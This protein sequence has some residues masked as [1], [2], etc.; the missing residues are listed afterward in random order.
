MKRAGGSTEVGRRV[1]RG[2]RE[3]AARAGVL[4]AELRAE[5]AATARANTAGAARRRRRGARYPKEPPLTPAGEIIA[6]RTAGWLRRMVGAPALTPGYETELAR[7][8]GPDLFG[9]LRLPDPPP[10]LAEVR[11]ETLD[12]AHI[13]PLLRRISMTGPAPDPADLTPAALAT[14]PGPVSA[15]HRTPG[16]RRW[17]QPAGTPALPADTVIPHVIHGIWLGG[18]ILAD[19][20]I[21]HHLRLGRD[22]PP[23]LRLRRVDRHRPRH[24]LKPPRPPRYRPPAPPTRTPRTATCSP[25]PATTASTSSTSTRSST[26]QR[27]MTLH[28]QYTAEHTKQLPRGYAGASDHLRLDIIH[29]L[30][31]TY[32]DGDNHITTTPAT[33]TAPPTSAPSLRGHPH[34]TV[35]RRGG[36]TTWLR[37]SPAARQ[38]S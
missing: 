34:R 17:E 38:G 12:P 9:L 15:Y 20:V 24:L 26:T 11:P 30:G 14:D 19:A 37:A 25:G 28:R 31:G 18:P 33:A 3:R 5:L 23:R 21:A 35:R 32:L 1:R 27:P 2:R 29:L 13:A 10:F 8:T 22:R 6:S 7:R 4:V 16:Q 36:V